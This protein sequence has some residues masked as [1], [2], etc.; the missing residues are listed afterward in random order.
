VG[1]R[2]PSR[3]VEDLLIAARN[4]WTVGLDNVSWMTNEWSD[5]LC[6]VAT[7]IASGTRAHYTNDEEHVYS[8]QRPILFN[9]IPSHLTER[10]DLAVGRSSYNSF[11]S[12]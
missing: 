1:L 11:Q 9:G 12:R 2:R 3:K 8:V 4:G 6:M 7:G 5:H 10:S